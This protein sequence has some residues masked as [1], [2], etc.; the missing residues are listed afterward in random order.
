MAFAKDHD[1]FVILGRHGRDGPQPGW[2]E[3]ADH[4]VPDELRGKLVGLIRRPR[5]ARP[6]LSTAPRRSFARVRGLCQQRRGLTAGICN[7][8]NN[9]TYL[10]DTN[11]QSRKDRR[12]TVVVD[13]SGSRRTRQASR[14]EVGVPRPRPP[15]PSPPPGGGRAGCRREDR[16]HGRSRLAGD[17]KIE[18]IMKSAPSPV[19]ASK[20]AKDLVEGAPKPLKKAFEATRPRRSRR[21]SRRSAPR[22]SSGIGLAPPAAPM[23][24][25]RSR[26]SPGAVHA[27]RGPVCPKAAGPCGFFGAT[28]PGSRPFGRRERGGE[29]PGV[30]PRARQDEEV[31]GATWRRRSPAGSVFVI[32]RAHPRSRGDAQPDRGSEGLL[33]S[34]PAGRRAEGRPSHEGLQS[35]FK[36][37][38]PISDFSARR[39]S[40]S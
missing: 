37:V 40:S 22:S 16:V 24:C 9:R 23:R 26:G 14:R 2:R 13:G 10:K 32:F 17:K 18:V 34:I 35:V 21:P 1:K 38:F 31:R 8:I 33:R 7:I 12:R 3:V 11:G 15:S 29:R 28:E 20:E 30:E 25:N 6:A 27:F 19:S 5:P 39:C 36:S 4:A